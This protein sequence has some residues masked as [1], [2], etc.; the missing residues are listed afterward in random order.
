MH[1]ISLCLMVKFPVPYSEPHRDYSRWKGKFAA[2][3][4][5]HL[6]WISPGIYCRFYQ[7]FMVGSTRYLQW[8]SPGVYGGFHRGDIGEL[9]MSLSLNWALRAR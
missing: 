9:R 3:S 1:R 2:I 4:T 5:R 8:I 7:I 6:W